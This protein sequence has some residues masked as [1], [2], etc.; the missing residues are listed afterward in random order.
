MT[1]AILIVLALL[2]LILLA[3]L[4]GRLIFPLPPLENRTPSFALPASTETSLGQRTLEASEIHPGL[5]GFIPLLSGYDALGSRLKL[6][7]HASASIDI[8]YYIWKDD[9]SGLLMAKA[10]LDAARRGVRVRLLLDDNGIPGLDGKLAALNS[11]ENLDVR[12]FNP[13]TIRRPKYLGYALDFPRMNRRMHNKSLIVDGAA[14]II[15][16]RNIGDEY[17]QVGDVDFYIDLDVLAVGPIVRDTAEMFD[18]YWNSDSVHPFENIVK[19]KGDLAALRANV[20]QAAASTEGQTVISDIVTSVEHFERRQ[21]SPEWTEITLYADD[22]KK[23]LAKATKDGL[24]ITRLTEIIGGV[25]RRLDLVSAYFV[26]GK[27]G[28]KIFSNLAKNGREVHILTNALNTTDVLVVHAGYTKYRRKL[29]KAGVNLFELKLRA[30]KSPGEEELPRFGL[31]GASLHAKTFAIDEERVFIGSFNF[32]PRSSLLN[33]E[34]GFLIDS[35]SLA[36]M[37]SAVFNGPVEMMSYRPVLTVEE[38]MVWTEKRT[39]GRDRIY[40]Q[41]PGATWFQQISIVIIGRLPVEWML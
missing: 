22:P 7:E 26:P 37:T 29:L 39:E 24:M 5:S 41:E 38:S 10:L 31:S 16:G 36:H 8:Q 35:K 14:A 12:L 23:G 11:A 20:D 21:I 2:L 32:D 34:M 6:I 4:I 25:Q 19:V 15:G 33:C 13:S 30:G 1:T 9:I 28:M 27:T 40:Q 3:I 17:F 18:R